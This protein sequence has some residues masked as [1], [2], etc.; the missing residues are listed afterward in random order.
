MQY[1]I[2]KVIDGEVREIALDEH[3]MYMISTAYERACAKKDVETEMQKFIDRYG[4]PHDSRETLVE[5]TVDKYLDYY[6][7]ADNGAW[8]TCLENACNEIID[9]YLNNN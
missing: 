5:D 9:E 8:I 3:D 2:H 7:D 4:I 1:I 6:G